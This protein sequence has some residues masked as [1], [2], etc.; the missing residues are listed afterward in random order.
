MDRRDAEA[1]PWMAE[2]TRNPWPTRVVWHQASRTQDRFAWLAVPEGTARKGATITAE[3]KGQ[4]IRVTTSGGIEA[5]TLRL[6]DA[7]K[8][9]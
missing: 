6:S 9:Y 2:H 8:T 1:L 7:H 3:A 5:L 4:E